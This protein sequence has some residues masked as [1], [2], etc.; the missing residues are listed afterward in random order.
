MRLMNAFV[1]LALIITLYYPQSSFASC[2]DGQLEPSE[3]CDPGGALHLDGN[4][5]LATCTTGGDCFYALSC[6]KFNCQFVGQG[7]SCFDGNAC[8][9]NDVCN[10]VGLCAAGGS[11]LAGT[12]CEDGLH[13]TTGDVCNSS[14]TCLAGGGDPCTGIECVS[15]C[16]EATDSCDVAVGAPCTDDGNVCTEDVCD[17]QASC[18]HPANTAPCSDGLFCNGADTCSGGSCSDH[19]GDPCANGGS[20]ANSCDEDA[21]TCNVANGTPCDDGLFCT[22]VDACASGLCVGSGDPCAGGEEC[23]TVCNEGADDCFDPNGS[24]CVDDG[25]PCTD[26]FCDGAGGCA[27]VANAAPCDDGLSCTS[28]DTCTGG[29]CLGDPPPAC[30][31][32]NPCTVDLCAEPS[33]K[34]VNLEEPNPVCVA[35]GISQLVISNRDDVVGRDKLKWRWKQPLDGTPIL[36]ADVGDPLMSTTYDLCVYDTTCAG[37]PP[38]PDP[39]TMSVSSLRAHVTVP[40]GGLWRDLSSKGRFL[41]RDRDALHGVSL[42]KVKMGTAPGLGVKA[43]KTN[44]ELTAINDTVFFEMDPRVIVQLVNSEGRCWSTTFETAVRNNARSFRTRLTKV[45]VN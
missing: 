11:A 13:C 36:L 21:D 7:A 27:H 17:A 6:C 30:D 9:T 12:A 43:S 40:P 22:V 1:G 41:Y 42:I 10:N 24:P 28:D 31:D 2:G 26:D 14:G 34:C 19:A 45:V 37:D 3:E 25:N 8:T 38:C 4:P 23:A 32:G 29:V 35:G 5:N 16:N 33:G 15:G 39:D 18:T 44:L 20:C